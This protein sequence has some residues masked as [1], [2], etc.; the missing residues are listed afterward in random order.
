MEGRVESLAR[1]ASDSLR[2]LRDPDQIIRHLRD[3]YRVAHPASGGV[4]RA[5]VDHRDATIRAFACM[6]LF[7]SGDAEDRS[8]VVRVLLNSHA[9]VLVYFLNNLQMLIWRG[10]PVPRGAFPEPLLRRSMEALE[11]FDGG[12]GFLSGAGRALM[13]LV[14]GSPL[15]SAVRETLIRAHNRKADEQSG[16]HLAEVVSDN[17]PDWNPFAVVTRLW[18]DE[19]FQIPP[20]AVADP[21]TAR[22]FAL[23]NLQPTSPAFGAAIAILAHR[24]TAEAE[25]M[26][27]DFLA[28]SD[29][30]ISRVAA[31]A[32]G[33]L[34]TPTARNRLLDAAR[35]RTNI[36]SLSHILEQVNRYPEAEV[37]LALIAAAMK[38]K[39]PDRSCAIRVLA[40]R[41]GSE[42]SQALVRLA[43]KGRPS[44][45][46]SAMDALAVRRDA[47]AVPIL[48]QA[49]EDSNNEV[50]AHAVAALLALRAW[51]AITPI[52]EGQ[53]QR[54]QGQW[55]RLDVPEDPAAPTE[56]LFA[57]SFLGWQAPEGKPGLVERVVDRIGDPDVRNRARRIGTAARWAAF[58]GLTVDER[59]AVA[60]AIREYV[61][62]VVNEYTA[63][64]IA[65]W[66][67][68]SLREEG[69]LIQILDFFVNGTA[70]SRP[71]KMALVLID[72][73]DAAER[74]PP[75]RSKEHLHATE[76]FVAGWLKKCDAADLADAF[77]A[78]VRG[79][80]SPSTRVLKVAT[81]Y[82]K[83]IGKRDPRAL[84]PKLDFLVELAFHD[85]TAVASEAVAI[86]RS[87]IVKG[88]VD[89]SLVLP[90]L[91]PL[92]DSERA[93]VKRGFLQILKELGP[94]VL[95]TDADL[96]Q[97]LQEVASSPRDPESIRN[98]ASALL[99]NL[100]IRV[101]P[102]SPADRIVARAA[103]PMAQVRKQAAR[104]LAFQESPPP[105]PAIAAC[106]RGFFGKLPDAPE[107]RLRSEHPL[108]LFADEV[109]KFT[110]SRRAAW[111]GALVNLWWS[112]LDLTTREPLAYV[113]ALLKDPASAPALVSALAY[114]GEG[115]YPAGSRYVSPETERRL[116]EALE[117]MP[118][119]AV[120]SILGTIPVAASS[121][122]AKLLEVLAEVDPG[123]F[124]R[125]FRAFL[126]ARD[127]EVRRAVLGAVFR[128]RKDVTDDL[129]QAC[130]R[131]PDEH[132]REIVSWHARFHFRPAY[133][134]S[135]RAALS[136]APTILSLPNLFWALES[137]GH[138]TGD[139]V[140]RLLRDERLNR[141]ART[142]VAQFAWK[143]DT[144]ETARAL[145]DAMA[146]DPHLA[147][148]A[149][150]QSLVHF[151]QPIGLREYIERVPEP[152]GWTA[153]G[154][155][156]RMA[157]QVDPSDAR[158]VLSNVAAHAD[159]ERRLLALLAASE[160]R[161]PLDQSL[162]DR[163][164]Q[165]PDERVRATAA[166]VAFT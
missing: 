17:A 29:S 137:N 139:D 23:S 58:A 4:A 67:S 88:G 113:L 152:G 128:L 91:T 103:H 156:S 77:P 163:L 83:I 151:K 99:T 16:R 21:E 76:T 27:A 36:H 9:E 89:P 43:A 108:E 165:D 51:N 97:R 56:L 154:I 65:L 127:P 119:V 7:E 147:R 131:D 100:G 102:A 140:V 44:I 159:P 166:H 69:L 96:Q 1:T 132:I 64:L 30:R 48:Q 6:M 141:E 107:L 63:L 33:N 114:A 52:I 92:L 10:V 14:R 47:G 143:T 98:D 50:F 25:P 78:V 117:E 122:R 19:R 153:R 120:P 157:Q 61:E 144:P 74:H 38:G 124:R 70:P 53:L 73:P 81:K 116:R 84:L 79:L 66:Y 136:M 3:V 142:F 26:F 158:A 112:P 15:D 118:R 57:L 106:L 90:K 111:V 2:R 41:P 46:T 11:R 104:D 5:F 40:N 42:V 110:P 155:A 133:L 71:A 161:V 123:E 31:T 59:D 129:V 149:G 75:L 37:T 39:D 87:A 164:R 20:E 125:I 82:L 138:L 95:R 150:D 32:L 12:A 126:D 93:P 135:I 94:D 45:R 162:R 8:T 134:E 54:L 115:N 146:A 55:I 34:Q 60:V 105:P 68:L 121:H 13:S 85:S 49:L 160:A 18:G 28:S 130:L 80:E 72:Y 62:A 101:V 24:P 145:V 109:G 35:N 86:L 148:W 22:R